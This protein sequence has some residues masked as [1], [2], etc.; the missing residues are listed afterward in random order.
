M[1][2]SIFPSKPPCG[3]RGWIKWATFLLLYFIKPDWGRGTQ[4]V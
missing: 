4:F 3:Y 2:L 1:H